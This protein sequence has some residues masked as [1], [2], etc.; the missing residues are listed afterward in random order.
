MTQ[1][2]INNIEVG[3]VFYT[4]WGIEVEM[5][6]P[7]LGWVIYSARSDDTVEFGR[8]VYAAAASGAYGAIEPRDLAAEGE[9][10]KRL[11][12]GTLARYDQ[13]ITNPHLTQD[14]IAALEAWRSQ[15][16]GLQEAEN[17]PDVDFPEFPVLHYGN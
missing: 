16:L 15:M 7:A 10:M 13:S 14:A 8:M 9:M 6:H 5:N 3:R 4:R 11:I 2:Q 17:W 12:A 1:E